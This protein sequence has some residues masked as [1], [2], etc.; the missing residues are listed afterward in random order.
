M[1]L[2]PAGSGSNC[3]FYSSA[4]AQAASEELKLNTLSRSL[5]LRRIF[6]RE[7]RKAPNCNRENS[8]SCCCDFIPAPPAPHARFIT[9]LLFPVYLTLHLL[10]QDIHR[11]WTICT[12]SKYSGN[13]LQWSCP[14]EPNPSL[15]VDDY[16]KLFVVISLADKW[17][18]IVLWHFGRQYCINMPGID[19]VQPRITATFPTGA[20]AWVVS[21]SSDTNRIKTSSY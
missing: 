3:S 19:T 16:L 12:K 6:K 20:A 17:Y 2:L 7:P 5:F 21:L 11:I 1:E 14:P 8:A 13:H 15:W 9:I 18:S 10:L 4:S